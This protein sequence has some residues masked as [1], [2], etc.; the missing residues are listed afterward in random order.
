MTTEEPAIHAEHLHKRYGDKIAVDD[1]SLRIDPGEVFGILGTNGAG[2]T[3]T[4]E[5]IAGLRK[6]DGGRVTLLGLDPRHDRGKVRQVLGVQLQQA[7][8]HGALTVAELMGLYRSFYPDPRSSGELLELVGLEEKRGVRFEK[9]SGGQQQRLSIALALAGRPRVLI[10]DELTTG[11]DPRA[12]R[13][14]WATI[15]HLRDEGVTIVLV[16]HAMEEVERLCDRVAL[17]DAGRVLAVEPPAGLVALA[18]AQNLDDAF[19]ALTG[20]QLEEAE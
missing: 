18:G 19:V 11:L 20:K 17:L 1:V 6:P 12:R 5:M 8:L 13:Q 3:T 2:K 9:L 14:M 4:V 15:E 10:L 7:Y 16:S